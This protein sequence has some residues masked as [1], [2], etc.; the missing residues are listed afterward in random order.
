M[1]NLGRG[2]K[3]EFLYALANML[4]LEEHLFEEAAAS[5]IAEARSRRK[6]LLD[7]GVRMLYDKD[8]S[9]VRLRRTWCILKHLLLAYYHILETFNMIAESG[10]A[11]EELRL[12]ARDLFE[13]AVSFF[14]NEANI[15]VDEHVVDNKENGEEIE[16]INQDSERRLVQPLRR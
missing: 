12:L 13:E 14:E 11:D 1:K 5:S 3:E 16:A 15:L 9:D 2:V 7:V 4:A 6:F 8:L 10:N